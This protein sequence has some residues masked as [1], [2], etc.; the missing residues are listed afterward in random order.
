MK[1]SRIAPLSLALLAALSLAACST[2]RAPG[3]QGADESTPAFCAKGPLKMGIE[4]FE[5]PS[6]LEPAYQVLAGALEK[7]LG[8]EVQVQVVED[9][10]AEVLAMRN[11]RLDIGQFGP[12]GFVFASEKANAEPLA[13]FGT[14]DGKLSTYTAGIWV[15]K[16]S[17]IKDINDLA[18]KDLALG[19][20]G[21]TSGD[22]LPRYALKK[23]GI[24][25]K[26]L[27]MNYAGGHPEALLALVN[28]TVDAAQLNSQTQA[29]AIASGNFT[30][31]DFRQIWASDPTPNDPITVSADADPAFKTAVRE[32]L[33]NLPADDVAAVGE[34]LDVTPAGKLLAVDKETYAPLFD[35]AATMGLTEKDL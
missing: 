23:A 9:Y 10:S 34:F 4:P 26:S 33:L 18:G 11:G 12:M 30:P 7:R 35:L 6:K 13:S 25:E 31:G 29:S 5:D 17:E 16:D 32:A 21:S 14:A 22:V 20:V 28:G 15:P 2:P 1:L 3:A 8:C 19:S 27:N 24:Q